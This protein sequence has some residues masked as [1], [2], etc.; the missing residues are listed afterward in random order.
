[1]T[2]SPAEELQKEAIR[3]ANEY[4]NRLES[5]INRLEGIAASG[6]STVPIDKDRLDPSHAE[7]E[8]I[9]VLGAARLDPAPPQPIPEPPTITSPEADLN[10]A[11]NKVV[12]IPPIPSIPAPSLKYPSLGDFSPSPNNRTVDRGAINFSTD[13]ITAYGRVTSGNVIH[14][15]TNLP[16]WSGDFMDVSRALQTPVPGTAEI[17]PAEFR[18]SQGKVN[19]PQ[20]L[21]VSP[22]PNTVT[23]TMASLNEVTAPNIPTPDS[24]DVM[25]FVPEARETVPP[26]IEM[27]E[28][29]FNLPLPPDVTQPSIVRPTTSMKEVASLIPDSVT[30]LTFEPIVLTGLTKQQPYTVTRPTIN[31]TSMRKVDRPT[32][33]MPDSPELRAVQLPD[34]EEVD[35]I[36]FTGEIPEFDVL[37]PTNL[38]EYSEHEY[39]SVLGDEARAQLLNNLINGGYGINTEDENALWARAREREN[40]GISA[41]TREATRQMAARGFSLPPGALLAQI[42]SAT[43][44]G[45]EKIS[46]ASRDIALK[47]ADMYVENR[48]FTFAQVKEMEQLA[49]TLHMS[50]AERALNTSKYV[51]EFGIN[52]FNLNVARYNAKLDGFKAGVIEFEAKVRQAAMKLETQKLKLQ[53]T[54]LELDTQKNYLQRFSTEVEAARTSIEVYKTD[55]DAA[56]S[57]AEADISVTRSKVDV[58]TAELGANKVI[59]DIYR[60]DVEAQKTLADV[61]LGEQRVKVDAYTAE[62]GAKRVAID[63]FQARLAEARAKA[64][65]ELGIAKM[66][67]EE[68]SAWNDSARMHTDRFTAY[69]NHDRNLAD[70]TLK[71]EQV[72]TDRMNTELNAAKNDIDLFQAKV[73]AVRTQA[74][75][76]TSMVKNEVDVFTARLGENRTKIEKFQAETAAARNAIDQYLGEQRLKVDA[77]NSL[78]DVA[79]TQIQENESIRNTEQARV[80][81]VIESNRTA[82]QAVSTQSEIR[83]AEL[84]EILA[85]IEKEKGRIDAAI[86]KNEREVSKWLAEY[87]AVKLDVDV[88]KADITYTNAALEKEKMRIDLFRADIADFEASL[89]QNTLQIQQFD[90]Q[91]RGDSTNATMYLSALEAQR[92]LIEVAKAQADINESNNRIAI[93]GLRAEIAAAQ[94]KASVYQAIASGVAANNTA[95]TQ[96]FSAR[97]EALK[98]VASI[99]GNMAGLDHNRFELNSKEEVEKSRLMLEENKLIWGTRTTASSISVEALGKAMQAALNQV[100]GIASTTSAAA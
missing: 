9:E 98:G 37:A 67:I 16:E 34:L 74:E 58:F 66:T 87:E 36:S 55:V 89:K 2:P 52:L 70:T 22:A 41:A 1:M 59:S 25:S 100:I 88:Y 19:I 14:T 90:A 15:P 68:F 10:S 75:I 23:P 81:T 80:N 27:P 57:E 92:K 91:M 60:T 69:S 65:I 93:E 45:Y 50:A 46:T 11:L 13:I 97:S 42:Q 26:S 53:R 17:Q 39:E 49:V 40:R 20:T 61:A 79:R 5:F 4:S 71:V 28:R 84:S 32:I 83:K 18:S 38:F 78:N 82:L 54:S 48:K 6:I 12:S 51:A 35:S 63:N 29:D 86:K 62:T 56:R 7:A 85:A 33:K 24:T 8:L 64:D 72:R 3:Q 47:R 73:G 95:Q 31:Q 77:F 94:G 30:S 43:Q 76:K 96:A 99:Y 21:T 44:D